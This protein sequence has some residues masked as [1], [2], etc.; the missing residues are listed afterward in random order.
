[1]TMHTLLK[2][3]LFYLL[4]FLKQNYILGQL[5]RLQ[6]SFSYKRKLWELRQEVNPE[7]H[8]KL[9]SKHRK[10]RL[11]ST[12]S[13]NANFNGFLVHNL[14]YFT[15]NFLRHSVYTRKYNYTDQQQFLNISEVCVLCKLKI[16]NEVP[17]STAEEAFILA[18]KKFLIAKSFFQLMNM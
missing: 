17:A 8:V 10:Y 15:F 12:S 6:K 9:H 16:C 18:L 7:F 11:D 13:T 5:Y 1:M 4:P 2:P 14:G 3:L